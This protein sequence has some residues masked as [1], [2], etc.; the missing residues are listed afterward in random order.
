[1]IAFDDENCPVALQNQVNA[2]TFS[3]H[4]FLGDNLVAVYLYGSLACGDFVMQNSDVD[5]IGVVKTRLNPFKRLAIAQKMLLWNKTPAP[6]EISLITLDHL[7]EQPPLRCQ[8]HFSTKWEKKYQD[9]IEKK[10]PTHWILKQDFEDPDIPAHL[11]LTRF[12]SI[13]LLGEKAS[14]VLPKISENDFVASVCADFKDLKWNPTDV[15]DCTYRILTLCR[16]LAFKERRKILSKNKAAQYAL[17]R[18]SLKKQAIVQRA[19]DFKFHQKAVKKFPAAALDD[20]ARD[21][22]FKIKDLMP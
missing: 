22:L 6:V 4:E 5:L 19:I 18:L 16:I 8:F 7:N 17:T 20:F 13:A 12:K 10:D 2:L 15:S 14:D 21:I 11:Y 3:L 9:F 1:M